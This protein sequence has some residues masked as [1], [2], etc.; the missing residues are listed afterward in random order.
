MSIFVV[1]YFEVITS[2]FTTVMAFSQ[3]NGLS[4]SLEKMK[5]LRDNELPKLLKDYEVKPSKQKQ[6]IEH[7]SKRTLQGAL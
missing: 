4:T 7:V 3:E 5:Q 2:L 1:S 6:I